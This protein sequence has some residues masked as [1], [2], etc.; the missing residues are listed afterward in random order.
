M[1]GTRERGR[2][3]SRSDRPP[4]SVA[5]P[6]PP[7]PPRYR[8]WAKQQFTFGAYT[9][10]HTIVILLGL[11]YCCVAPLITVFCVLYFALVIV[12]QKY[13]LVYALTHPYET[14]G[15]L[16]LTVRGRGEAGRSWGG[17]GELGGIRAEAAL[18]GSGGCNWQRAPC[19]FMGHGSP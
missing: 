15:R 1:F 9:A 19:G 17:G 12:A 2:T 18:L 11:A 14:N 13:Q 4:S 7:A 3:W 6:T 8:L 5:R 16:W 10:R